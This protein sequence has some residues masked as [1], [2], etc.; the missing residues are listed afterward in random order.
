MT[1][2][3]G[4]DRVRS[5]PICSRLSATGLA[6][7]L[8]LSLSCVE[9]GDFAA[10]GG[11]SGTGISQG[12]ITAFG[13]IFV[14]GVEW[15]LGGASIEIDGDTS[16]SETDLSLGMVVRIEGRR[17]SDGL[18]GNAT[19]VSFDDS[20]EGPIENIQ[21][22]MPGIREFE[23]L[24]VPVTIELGFTHFDDGATYEGLADDDVV[25]VSGFVDE[26]GGIRA[27]RVELKGTFLPGATE[28][29]LKGT[30]TNLDLANKSFSLGPI[31]VRYVVSDPP[32]EGDT[33]FEDLADE[34]ELSDG[35]FVEVKGTLR[36]S[37][38]LDA[39]RIERED[40][41]LGAEDSDDV[42]LEGIVTRVRSQIDFDVAGVRVDASSNPTLDPPGLVIV[43]GL[44]LEVEGSLSG[45]VL[46]A[47][48]IER[49]DED[50][51]DSVRIRAAVTSVDGA[52]RTLVIL[53]I[54]VRADGHT[55]LR[56]ERD[57]ELPN[58]RFEDI[59]AGDWLRVEGGE[60]GPGA[61]LASRIRR[62]EPEDDVVLRGPVT[63]FATDPNPRAFDILDQPIPIHS[64]TA[65]R[66]SLDG[67]MTEDE[68]FSAIRTDR[69]VKAVD[70]DA[71]PLRL[72]VLIEAD[73]VDFED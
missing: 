3:Y 64:G 51:E 32:A 2:E 61:V 29:E 47:D 71:D 20:I 54:L 4:I 23:I 5:R 37:D 52:A 25:E 62:D 67:P 26:S 72:D 6:L 14:N 49:E 44:Q 69:I 1:D 50:D 24:G 11:M 46:L 39:S 30:I 15:E 13:S 7:A 8:A 10:T 68:F 48:E 57:D 45:G 63:F 9:G 31:F 41:G 58:F 18:S 16:A 42:E 40:G 36:R 56:D 38:E 22:G 27:T 53:E 73:E 33:E 21:D 35:L 19:T 59:E 28:A 66:D 43:E 60:A 34:S 17:S 65:Y 55:E 70:K 12:S